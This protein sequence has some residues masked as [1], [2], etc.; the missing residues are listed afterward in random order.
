MRFIVKNP[1]IL[2]E[3]LAGKKHLK[4]I[5]IKRFLSFIQQIEKSHKVLPKLLLH[6]IKRDC[7]STTGSNLRNI[8]LNT[9]HDDVDKLMP[10]DAFQ[11][12]FEEVKEENEWKINIVKELID[13]KWGEVIIENLLFDEIDNLLEEICTN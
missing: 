8:L 6:T 2:F 5:L 9:N 7:R 13:A 12:K 10:N 11:I 1:Y 3:P 4:T